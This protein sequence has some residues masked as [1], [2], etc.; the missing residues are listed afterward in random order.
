MLISEMPC[1]IERVTDVEHA[2]EVGDPLAAYFDVARGAFSPNTERALRAD[3]EIFAAWCRHHLR[4]AV[5]ASAATVVTFIDD[6]ARVRAPA[7]VRRYVSSIATLHKALRHTNPLEHARVRFALQRMHRRRGRRQ[8]QVQGTDLAAAKP[9]AGGGRRPAD[10]C[11][12]PRAPGDGLRHAAAAL[13]AGVAG[14]G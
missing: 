9:V 4:V 1:D 14:T 12:E 3:V 7:T 8:A 11:P 2:A 13:R 10:R 5:P 6:R